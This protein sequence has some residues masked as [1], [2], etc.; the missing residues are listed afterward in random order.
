MALRPILPRQMQ[1]LLSCNRSV[2]EPFVTRIAV[3]LLPYIWLMLNWSRENDSRIP[4]CIADGGQAV[5]GGARNDAQ[6]STPG[7][8]AQRVGFRSL[9]IAAIPV[10]AMRIQRQGIGAESRLGSNPRQNIRR[11]RRMIAV[12]TNILVS[13]HRAD[14][15]WHRA[16]DHCLAELAESGKPWAIPWPC[17]HEFLA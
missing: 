6:R 9:R 12:D 3:L 4:G 16:A 1:A 2:T 5:R 7:G 10:E 14:S 17:M 11:T 13:A 15:P 8:S